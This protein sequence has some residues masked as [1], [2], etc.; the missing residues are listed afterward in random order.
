MTGEDA[1]NS[2]SA[3]CLKAAVLVYMA[4]FYHQITPDMAAVLWRRKAQLQAWLM[5]SLRSVREPL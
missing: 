1:A 5:M 3:R 4:I 2:G